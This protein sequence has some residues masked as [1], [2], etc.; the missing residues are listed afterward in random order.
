MKD[1]HR[2]TA[3]DEKLT[4][5]LE[6]QR[7]TLAGGEVDS[8]PVDETVV[9]SGSA[10]QIMEQLVQIEFELLCGVEAKELL[11]CQWLKPDKELRSP[12]IVAV[13][14]RFNRVCSWAVT[15]ILSRSDPKVV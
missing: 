15:E 13:T 9:V 10:Q 12:A 4:K 14:K 2:Q 11:G 1:F 8:I 7:S 5:E 6:Q 3:G